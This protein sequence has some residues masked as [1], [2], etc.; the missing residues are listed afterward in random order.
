M[1][2]GISCR[3][4]SFPPEGTIKTKE[5]WLHMNAGDA[6]YMQLSNPLSRSASMRIVESRPSL[7]FSTREIPGFYFSKSKDHPRLFVVHYIY[8]T[9]ERA[10]GGFVNQ[11][12]SIILSHVYVSGSR[13]LTLKI[14]QL[15]N[16]AFL[17]AARE[18]GTQICQPAEQLISGRCIHC[19]IRKCLTA[20]TWN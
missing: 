4:T 6:A 14:V 11:P 19:G 5:S 7:A 12:C 20:E 10:L 8:R 1:H 3:Q 9:T 17:L 15:V 18:H 2:K 13:L 16:F